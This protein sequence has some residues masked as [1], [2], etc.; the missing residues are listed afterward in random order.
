MLYPVKRR[1]SPGKFPQRALLSSP[2][3]IIFSFFRSPGSS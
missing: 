3:L 2:L 1:Y